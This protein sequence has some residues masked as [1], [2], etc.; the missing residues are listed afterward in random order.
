MNNLLPA[1]IGR[2]VRKV[3]ILKMGWTQANLAEATGLTVEAISRIEN[4]RNQGPPRLST[5]QR[6]AEATGVPITTFTE[7]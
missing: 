1:D 3:R 4:S 5:L 7:G 2:R 6:I